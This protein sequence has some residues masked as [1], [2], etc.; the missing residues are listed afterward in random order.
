M[1]ILVIYPQPDFVR[2]PRFGFSYELLTL[3]TVLEKSH[4][5]YIKDYSCEEYS[6]DQLIEFCCKASIEIALIECD[7]FAL[8]RSQNIVH[9]SQI[10]NLLSSSIRTIAYGNYCY[11]TKKCFSSATHTITENDINAIV[12]VVNRYSAEQLEKIESFDDLPYVNRKLLLSI[13]YYAR[14]SLCTLLQTA[15]GCENTCIFCQ[16][17]GWQSH[18]VKHSDDY[19]INELIEIKQQGYK[20][21]WI[22][23]ENFT[24]DLPRAKRLLRRIAK[25]SSINNLNFFISTWANID[26][27][28]IR[29]AATCNIRIMSFGIESG[30]QDILKYYRKNININSVPDT[31]RYA[32][33]CGIFTVGN[34]IIGAPKETRKSIEQTFSLIKECEF[35]QVNIK[36]LDY[37]IGSELYESLS[38]EQRQADSIF[39]CKENNLSAFTLEEMIQIKESFLKDYYK[40]HKKVIEAKIKRFGRPYNTVF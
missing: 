31:I 30:N 20:D 12:T 19:V 7:S 40:E 9:A 25:E 4:R 18:Y 35:D 23:D 11:I 39:S 34:F 15:K 8:K 27:E 22:I 21:I 28:F 13:P 36:I 33:M 37:M 38:V 32:N 26:C 14:Y 1:N 16:R 5:V 17:K 29:L 24:F 2:K 3:A 6:R 10:I